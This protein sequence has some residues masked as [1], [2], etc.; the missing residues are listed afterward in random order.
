MRAGKELHRVVYD[1]RLGEEQERSFP[2]LLESLVQ[3]NQQITPDR[4]IRLDVGDE[5]PL[6][7]L[8]E[9]DSEL[10][11]ILQEALTNARRHS[12]AKNVLVSLGAK[13]DR[14]W[15]EVK[16]DGRGFDPKA[17]TT[18]MGIKGMRERA[19]TLKG[20][21]KIESEPGEG[22]KVR[23]EAVLERDEKEPEE[24]ARIL[25]VE[26]HA[27][28]RQAVASMFE[29]EPGFTVTGQAGSLAEAR[30]MLDG[31]DLAIIDLGLPDGYGG[32]LIKELREATPQAQALVLSASIDRAEIAR[33]VEAGAAGVLHKSV[34]IGEVVETVRRLRAGETL[35]SL[36]EVVE[37]LRYAGSERDRDEEARQAIEQL[38]PREKEVLQAL[39]DGLDGKEIAERLHI[40]DKTERNHIAS[41]LEK[42]GVHSRLQ[43][44]VFAVRYDVAEIRRKAGEE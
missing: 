1:L 32:E 23:F 43:A 36:E 5:F 22:T 31:I 35:L 7:P 11:R 8:D 2:E 18:G 21:L 42:L 33:A 19:R 28:F 14:L 12:G 34:S 39:A 26:D 4:N 27:S 15:A 3:L 41:I 6:K 9:K 29:R 25:L 24:E 13:E 10:L 20:D 30:Q 37:L 44:L 40:S 17:A 38:T 16:D